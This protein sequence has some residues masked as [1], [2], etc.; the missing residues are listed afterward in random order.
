MPRPYPARVT[1]KQPFE[2]DRSRL[3]LI[4]PAPDV[5]P[6]IEQDERDAELRRELQRFYAE[7]W[8]MARAQQNPQWRNA[9]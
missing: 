1:A 3:Q 8:A 5:L 6:E 9:K 2:R 4:G 7:T